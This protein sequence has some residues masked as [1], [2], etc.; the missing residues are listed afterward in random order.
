MLR[1]YVALPS[2]PENAFLSIVSGLKKLCNSI[3]WGKRS[4]KFTWVNFGKSRTWTQRRSCVDRRLRN[5]RAKTHRA[6]YLF[7]IILF[8][9]ANSCASYY[10]SSCDYSPVWRGKKARVVSG[11]CSLFFLSA[12][13]TQWVSKNTKTTVAVRQWRLWSVRMRILF[14]LFQVKKRTTRH[15]YTQNDPNKFRNTSFILLVERI[16]SCGNFTVL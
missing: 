6:V 16:P 12:E 15:F 13:R 3:N 14:P 7:S 4:L 2:Q 9:S 11:F 1:R 8:Q 5:G 10:P